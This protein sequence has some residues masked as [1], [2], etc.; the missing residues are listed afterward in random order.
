MFVDEIAEFRC[1]ASLFDFP[2]RIPKVSVDFFEGIRK[3]IFSAMEKCYLKYNTL[4]YEMVSVFYGSPLPPVLDA[5]RGFN[6]DPLID[7]LA[8]LAKKRILLKKIDRIHQLVQQ[9][10]ID[11]EDIKN[12][13]SFPSFCFSSSSSLQ[14]GILEFGRDLKKKLKNE[15]VFVDTGIHF[16]NEMLGGEWPRQGLTVIIGEGGSGKTALICNSM[17]EMAKNGTASYFQSL[18]MTKERLVARF[19]AS[20][21]EINGLRIRSGKLS[22]EEIHKVAEATSLLSNLPIFIDDTPGVS[23]NRIVDQISYHTKQHNVKVAF[24]DYLQIIGDSFFQDGNMSDH[25]GYLALE[26]RNAA[27]KN[28]IAVVLLSQQNRTHS[29]LHSI[30]GSGRVGHIADVVIELSCSSKH[31]TLRPVQV[32]LH[33][34]RDGPLGVQTVAYQTEYLKFT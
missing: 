7:Y 16:L 14:D 3:D 27:V 6:P 23:I 20:L 29:G 10:Y 15:Y 5:S 8:I 12:V 24:V 32:E 25:Y 2:D 9:S 34:N 28:D 31:E 19:V 13:L 22:E 4:S 21:A 33:K 1:L 30:L 17:L 26:L 18:E 11:D